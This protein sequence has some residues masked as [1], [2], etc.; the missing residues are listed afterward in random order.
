MDKTPDS[1]DSDAINLLDS[2]MLTYSTRELVSAQDVLDLLL[3]IRLLLISNENDTA[4]V[5]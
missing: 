4:T 3:D 5:V 2:A 1:V